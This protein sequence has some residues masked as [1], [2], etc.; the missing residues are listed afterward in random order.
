MIYVTGDMHGDLARFQDKALRKLRRNDVLIVCGDFGFVWD[1][2]PKEEQALR[3]I[4]RRKYHV[5]FVDGAHDNHTLLERYPEAVWSGGK[6]REISG[7]LKML[8]RGELFY[9]EDK[10]LFA[11]GGGF[12]DDSD[13]TSAPGALPSKGDIE[14]ARENL[15]R[16]RHQ[17]DYIIT[18]QPSRKI[19]QAVF[20]ER[21]NTTTL[22]SFLDEVRETCNYS[23]WFFG[24]IHKNKIIPPGEIGLFTNVMAA[25]APLAG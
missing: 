5:L 20:P 14:R 13:P 6:V 4:G 9:I 22:D 18:H 17:V 21:P 2:S 12:P 3:W 8:G 10:S 1:G 16:A 15:E 25:D 24:S 19:A 11:F 23:R 7:K